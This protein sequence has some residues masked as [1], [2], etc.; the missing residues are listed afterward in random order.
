MKTVGGLI[1]LWLAIGI[2]LF[3]VVAAVCGGELTIT[4]QSFP[5]GQELKPGVAVLICVEGL[6]TGQQAIWHYDKQEGDVVLP[7]GEY[8]LFAGT[9]AGPRTFV[10][11]VPSDGAD[12][13]AMETFQYGVKDDPEP[14]PHPT[15]DEVSWAIIIEERSDRTKLPIQQ[16]FV[17]E[18]EKLRKLLPG[19]RFRVKD[20]D[21]QE[22][23]YARFIEPARKIGLPALFLA[24][25]KGAI[26]FSGPL[27]AT[28]E[29]T[30]ELLRK[31]G[32]E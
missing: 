9:A 4:A 30:A 22:A 14:D 7:I 17:F 23:E 28:V 19:D 27:P 21:V 24:D 2:I 10:V 13:F 18:S 32:R 11:Q 12:P 15:P 29:A 26:V 16:R 31:Y 6:K 20:D 5:P 1:L 3:C 8:H 25:E